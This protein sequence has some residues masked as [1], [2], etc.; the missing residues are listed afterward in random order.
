MKERIDE[1]DMTKN[2][3]EIMRGGYKSLLKEA[4]DPTVAAQPTDPNA[5]PA[6]APNAADPNAEGNQQEN[7]IRALKPD[8]NNPDVLTIATT[9]NGKLEVNPNKD[10]PNVYNTELNNLQNIIDTSAKITSFI[11]YVGADKDV[12]IKA[13]ILDKL[14]VT[15][16]YSENEMITNSNNLPTNEETAKIV[17]ELVGFFKVWKKRW[18]KDINEYKPDQNTAV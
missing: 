15:F 14:S 11:I 1:H 4:E 5:A 2:M 18:G 9:E 10:Y 3:M 17:G 7:D 6:P 12:E 16:R 8:P 13:T